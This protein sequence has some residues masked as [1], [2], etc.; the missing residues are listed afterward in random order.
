MTRGSSMVLSV[1]NLPQ[2]VAIVD[3][4]DYFAR[5]AKEQI[6]S[7]LLHKVSGS[8]HASIRYSSIEACEKAMARFNGSTFRGSPVSC[9]IEDIQPE[10]GFDKEVVPPSAKRWPTPSTEWAPQGVIIQEDGSDLV[11][12]RADA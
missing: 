8:Q 2:N 11:F 3:V 10:H 5:E 4:K 6:S 9:K 12:W 7:V 1:H